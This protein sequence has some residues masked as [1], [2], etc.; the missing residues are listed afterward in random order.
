LKDKLSRTS[1]NTLWGFDNV[2]IRA[3]V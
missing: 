3:T 1:L 2:A